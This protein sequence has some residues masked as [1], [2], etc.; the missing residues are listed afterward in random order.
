MPYPSEDGVP[1]LEYM[2]N[3]FCIFKSEDEAKEQ[4]SRFLIDFLCN[5]KEVAAENVVRSGAF[6][7]RT[8]METSMKETRKRSF[9]KR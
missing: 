6:P 9:T 1:S 5:D 3:G 4:A 2:L 7:V 8:S